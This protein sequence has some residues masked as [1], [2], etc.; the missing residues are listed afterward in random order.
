[1]FL[2]F[3]DRGNSINIPHR[4]TNTHSKAAKRRKK[5]QQKILKAANKGKNSRNRFADNFEVLM[6]MKN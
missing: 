3:S 5:Q 1:M 4:K 2:L 6:L